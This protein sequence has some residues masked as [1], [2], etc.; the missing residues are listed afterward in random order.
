MT[1]PRSCSARMPSVVGVAEDG[2]HRQRHLLQQARRRWRTAAS[3][4]RSA[5]RAARA[6]STAPS[7][8]MIRKYRRSDASPVSGTTRGVASGRA[9]SRAGS[10]RS[11]RGAVSGLKVHGSRVQRVRFQVQ[12]SDERA[13]RPSPRTRIARRCDA[14]AGTRDAVGDDALVERRAGAHLHIVPQNRPRDAR[15]RVDPTRRGRRSSA[16]G[17]LGG[18]ERE[19]RAPV[20]GR[21]ADVVER[22]V[23]D[24]AADRRPAAT[25]SARRRRRR[26]SWP[27]SPGATA[28]KTRPATIC[29]PMK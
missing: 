26:S 4:S 14:P 17:A 29:T 16:I 8:G 19:R 21:R 18:R 6:R 15:G 27:A 9:R 2:R 28:S 7:A 11:G 23:G 12:R 5:R 10:D 13:R 3:R 24:D 25:R 22:R 1:S 20:V